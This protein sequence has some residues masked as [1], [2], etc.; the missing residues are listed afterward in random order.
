MNRHVPFGH[1]IR[2]LIGNSARM[3]PLKEVT[4]DTWVMELDSFV[5]NETYTYAEFSGGALMRT[6]V[7]PHLFPSSV[8]D[9]TVYEM[10]DSWNELF[11]PYT[12]Q[13]FQEVVFSRR[14]EG[15][16]TANGRA[17]VVLRCK[18]QSVPSGHS[19]YVVGSS[20]MVGEW[21]SSRALRMSSVGGSWWEVSVDVDNLRNAFEYKY[22]IKKT[23]LVW[24]DGPNRL[25]A[26]MFG[27]L[28]GSE[29]AVIYQEDLV[30]FP[31]SYK[32]VGVKVCVT[33]IKGDGCGCGDLDD[34]MGVVDLCQKTGIS[35]VE[36][37]PVNDYATDVHTPCSL[38]ALDPAMVGLKEFMADDHITKLVEAARRDVE[39]E[40][41]V[42]RGR[43]LCKKSKILHAIFATMKDEYRN[44]KEILLGD[45]EGV[46]GVELFA[47]ENK[48]W[49]LPYVLY[50]TYGMDGAPTQ[51]NF[52]TKFSE[53]CDECTF[54]VFVQYTL[55]KQLAR[56]AEYAREKHLGLALTLPFTVSHDSVETWIH[57]NYFFVNRTIVDPINLH[58]KY[59]APYNWEELERSKYS[60]LK[61]RVERMEKISPIIRLENLSFYF[62]TW[63]VPSGTCTGFFCPQRGYTKQ[64]LANRGIVDL[65]R[66]VYSYIRDGTLERLFGDDKDFVV[67]NFL[68][69]NNDGTYNLSPSYRTEDDIVNHSGLKQ[70]RASDRRI[71]GGLL[72]ILH[73]VCLLATDDTYIPSPTMRETESSFGELDPHTRQLLEKLYIDFYENRNMQIWKQQGKRVLQAICNQTSL[74]TGD[75]DR[76]FFGELRGLNIYANDPFSYNSFIDSSSEQTLRAYWECNREMVWNQL[77]RGGSAPSFCTPQLMADL[78]TFNLSQMPMFVVVNLQDILALRE[79]YTRD[80]NP[81]HEAWESDGALRYRCHVRLSTLLGDTA[82]HQVVQRLV[83]E[84]GRNMN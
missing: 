8:D 27:P 23:H 57:P 84:S 66:L 69:D 65:D 32:A 41:L 64:D 22:F 83:D 55:Y 82:L 37:M 25:F 33:G 45:R 3:S 73:N 31:G 14:T 44:V 78:L 19:V 5:P 30:K 39:Y 21:D 35:V 76:S 17:T 67:E 10:R 42:D 12:P 11:E 62:R 46:E 56:V 7:C 68:I 6:E 63:Q 60:L 1:T 38:F 80:R 16:P 34:M 36:L 54:H 53:Q 40:P 20:A 81:H 75:A 49:L 59:G 51:S 71:V 58:R 18:W 26:P 72:S 79:E 29:R 4:K 52:E 48:K 2:V 13:F 28:I 70:S 77:R 61:E 47:Y 43:V 50:K 15:R 24:E 74:F 9:A